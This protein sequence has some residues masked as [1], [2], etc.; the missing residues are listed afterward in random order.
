MAN[1]SMTVFRDRSGK[2]GTG[3]ANGR[4]V[5]CASM[6]LFCLV[7][8]CGC[9]TGKPGG[10]TRL[11]DTDFFVAVCFQDVD[12]VRSMVVQNPRL[13]HATYDPS[14]ERHL[15]L[16]NIFP[17]PITQDTRG[18]TA[19]HFASFVSSAK[20]SRKEVVKLLIGKGAD[21]NARTSKGATP[22]HFAVMHG[23]TELA[24]LLITNGAAVNA[25]DVHRRTP[26]YWCLKLSSESGRKQMFELLLGLG[27]R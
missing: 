16:N 22:L 7:M 5:M 1:R 13:V 8:L 12:K 10:G 23:D 9:V 27:G 3:V 15:L 4:L 11:K 2:G 20:K 14:Q 24:Q 18:F 19:L 21:V 26:M 6:I 25:E 17:A